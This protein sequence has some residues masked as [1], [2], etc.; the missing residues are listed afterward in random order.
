MDTVCDLTVIERTDFSDVCQAIATVGFN[1]NTSEGKK[2][3]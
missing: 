2:E 1:S 3:E